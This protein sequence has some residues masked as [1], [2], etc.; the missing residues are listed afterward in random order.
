M[1]LSRL[2]LEEEFRSGPFDATDD[3]GYEG[4]GLEGAHQKPW[5][6][7]ASKGALSNVPLANPGYLFK[8]F[9]GMVPGGWVPKLNSDLK[10]IVHRL[11]KDKVYWRKLMDF[12]VNWLRDSDEG[13]LG[14]GNMQ[15]IHE[16]ALDI[17]DKMGY[18][19]EEWDLG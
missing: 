15:D 13:S 18:G 5:N 10:W 3:E 8:Y 9:K 16:Y 1:K 6:K 19:D 11:M 7:V 4:G 17:A 14:Y 12:I 2:F